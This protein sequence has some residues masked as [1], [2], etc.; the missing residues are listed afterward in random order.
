VT[1]AQEKRIR[2]LLLAAIDMEQAKEAAR[3]IEREGEREAAGKEP[4]VQLVRAL[5][6]ALAVC[7]WRPFTNNSVGRLDP[8][9]DGSSGSGLADLHRTLKSMR[10]KAYAHTDV[11]SGRRA[12][13]KEHV[14]EAGVSGVVFGEGGGRSR[15]NGYPTSSLSRRVSATASAPRRCSFRLSSGCSRTWRR[16]DGHP[17]AR[18][19]LRCRELQASALSTSGEVVRSR[20]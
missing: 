10:D 12:D 14:T 6:A 1:E 18:T 17:P 15:A 11:Q 9:A 8:V 7:Y 13:V 4:N 19:V 3:A 5:E 16:S 20:A 2:V